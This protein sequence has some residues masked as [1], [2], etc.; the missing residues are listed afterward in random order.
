[1][2]IVIIVDS[3]KNVKIA[4][5]RNSQGLSSELG[6]PGQMRGGPSPGPENRVIFDSKQDGHNFSSEFE[7]FGFLGIRF[8]TNHYRTKPLPQNSKP[9]TEPG[10]AK[11]FKSR[12]G[13]RPVTS[14]VENFKI[15][16]DRFDQ[17]SD[18]KVCEIGYIWD[19]P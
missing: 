4:N 7:L 3:N 15:R 19:C 12:T 8:E 18:I 16:T 13:P 14:P 10:S 2:N 1:M 6:T 17:I 9:L 5:F 11:N